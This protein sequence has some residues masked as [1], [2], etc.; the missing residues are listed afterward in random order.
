M[1]G[2]SAVNDVTS[3][4]NLNTVTEEELGSNMSDESSGTMSDIEHLYGYATETGTNELHRR[5]L[6][7]EVFEYYD[8]FH[9]ELKPVFECYSSDDLLSHDP[10]DQSKPLIHHVIHNREPVASAL[11]TFQVS[12]DQMETVRQQYDLPTLDFQLEFPYSFDFSTYISRLRRSFLNQSGWH[13][14]RINIDDEYQEIGFLSPLDVVLRE[15][16]KKFGGAEGLQQFRSTEKDGSRCYSSILDSTLIENDER[17]IPINGKPI[18]FSIYV[19]GTQITSNRATEAIVFRVR[20][21]NLPKGQQVWRTVGILVRKKYGT[22]SVGISE[23]KRR[24]VHR[25]LFQ[26][27]KPLCLNPYIQDGVCARISCL[28]VDQPQERDLMCLLRANTFRNC[29]SCRNMFGSSVERAQEYTGVPENEDDVMHE[30]NEVDGDAYDV[31]QDGS[32]LPQDDHDVP[33]DVPCSNC[34]IHQTEENETGSN[35][36]PSEN[37]NVPFN[38]PSDSVKMYAD[39][40]SFNCTPRDVEETVGRQLEMAVL[41]QVLKDGDTV[42]SHLHKSVINSVATTNFSIPIYISDLKRALRHE[43]A[44]EFP[45]VLACLP[46]LGTPPFR[47]FKS[48]A[49]D[50]LHV[51]DLGLSKS[52]ADNMH[53]TVSQS[54]YHGTLRKTDIMKIANSR[55]LKLPYLPRV[56]RFAPFR[57]HVTDKQAPFTGAHWRSLVPFFWYVVLGLNQ[58]KPPDEDDLFITGLHLD[59]FYATLRQVNKLTSESNGFNIAEINRIEKFGRLSCQLMKRICDQPETTK[60]H[61]TMYH[62]SE[63]LQMYGNVS[64]GDTGSNESLHKGLK[65]SSIATNKKGYSLG[66]QILQVNCLPEYMEEED[67]HSDGLCFRDRVITDNIFVS[68]YDEITSSANSLEKYNET[69]FLSIMLGADVEKVAIGA[70]DDP[71]AILQCI[72]NT[73]NEY[74]LSRKYTLVRV[75]Q[76]TC[77]LPIRDFH[78]TSVRQV[79][80]CEQ[81]H[82]VF[83]NYMDAVQYQQKRVEPFGNRPLLH[84]GFIQAILYSKP[85]HSCSSEEDLQPICMIRRL[86]RAEPE[87]GNKRIVEDFQYTRLQYEIGDQDANLDF[88]PLQN[89]MKKVFILPDLRWLSTY[90]DDFSLHYDRKYDDQSFRKN[91]KFFHMKNVLE[92]CKSESNIVSTP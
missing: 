7:V 17:F 33:D 3:I 2:L 62:L 46:L 5:P 49:F 29:S 39:E 11:R 48:V 1:D 69:Y 71:D 84:F 37:S 9:D 64:F 61:R 70:S 79:I 76:L 13:E 56:N 31:N 10:C 24:V 44:R 53:I 75:A 12:M 43:C 68:K 82:D 30:E 36:E 23:K 14:V 34:S 81:K 38:S 77:Y 26:M 80:R 66:L 15:M 54:S 42:D 92:S 60:Q 67:L 27:I 52:Y 22:E 28:L 73:K 35:N 89:I 21:D 59:R 16:L 72:L 90:Y 25:L 87:D 74:E 45:S 86:E 57:A 19:D 20:I 91:A 41:T 65:K 63:Y 58:T 78:A 40:D 51:L 50:A 85:L 32:D 6:N 55:V 8:G 47:L 18:Y 88:V 83:W 4:P